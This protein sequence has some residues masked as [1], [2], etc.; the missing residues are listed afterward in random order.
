MAAYSG[1]SPRHATKAGEHANLFGFKPSHFSMAG[2]RKK[3][4]GSQNAEGLFEHS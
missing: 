3:G 2:K 1:H 4:K